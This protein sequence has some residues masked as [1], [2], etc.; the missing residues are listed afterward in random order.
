[1]LF[2][3]VICSLVRV[4]VLGLFWFLLGCWLGRFV[5]MCDVCWK[6]YSGVLWVGVFGVLECS[7]LMSL[8]VDFGVWLLKNF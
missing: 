3:F 7:E 2:F 4:G 5:R 6:L 8:C 1:M